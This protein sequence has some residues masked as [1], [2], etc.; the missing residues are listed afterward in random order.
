MPSVVLGCGHLTLWDLTLLA[1]CICCTTVGILEERP[2]KNGYAMRLAIFC[3]KVLQ[4][5]EETAGLE[6]V[7]RMCVLEMKAVV[8]SRMV[9]NSW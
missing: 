8:V 5:F 2:A 4:K 1:D 6:T 9:C 3:S 7:G